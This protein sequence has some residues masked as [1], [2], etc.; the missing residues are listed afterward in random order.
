M[1]KNRFFDL[2]GHIPVYNVRGLFICK[3]YTEMIGM[4]ANRAYEL[5]QQEDICKDLRSHNIPMEINLKTI[6]ELVSELGEKL[7]GQ[8]LAVVDMDMLEDEFR[9]IMF[10]SRI[11]DMQLSKIEEINDDLQWESERIAD[12]EERIELLGTAI[13]LY[14]DNLNQAI[15]RG[16]KVY[17]KRMY[18]VEE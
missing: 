10:T 2:E 18:G 13:D 15:V 9:P 1:G 6:G 11:I 17:R 3:L 14:I 8:M 4:Y 7:E 12:F 16:N 5:T